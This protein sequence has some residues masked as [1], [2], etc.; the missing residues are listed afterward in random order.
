VTRDQDAAPLEHGRGN[1]AASNHRD[2]RTALREADWEALLPGL[3]AYAARR[4]RLV[5][6][7][8]GRDEEPSAMSVQEVINIAIERCLDGSRSWDEGDPP[9]LGAFLCGVIKSITSTERKKWVRTKTAPVEDAGHNDPDDAASATELLE[10]DEGRKIL[11]AEVAACTEGDEELGLLYLAIQ[12]GA[13]KRDDIAAA[14]G[15]T[16]AR[17]SAARV[18]LQR[19]LLRAFPEKYAAYKKRRVAS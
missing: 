4:L 11:A 15:W 12:E 3:T 1:V 10:E 9:E 16:P 13:L 5:G 8:E 7:P 2:L 17:V 14:L 18:K 6:W 19:C